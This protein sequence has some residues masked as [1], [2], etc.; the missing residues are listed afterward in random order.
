MAYCTI[1]DM[2]DILP[3]N[4]TIGDSTA[5]SITSAK[6]NS[7]STATASKFIY[8]ATQFIDS[9]LS[10]I[11]VIPLIKIRKISINIIANI[12]P[13]SYDVM[14]EDVSAFF[15][16]CTVHLSDDNGSENAMVG[17]IAENWIEGGASVKN[18]NHLTLA[19]PTVQAYDAGSNAKVHLLVYPDPIPVLTARLACSF[20]FDKLFVAEQ[21][22]DISNYGK[23]LR[24]MST[25]DMNGILSGQVRL[26]GQEFVSRRFVRNQLFDAVRLNIEN[27]TYEQGKE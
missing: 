13:G 12:M 8:F 19:T 11:Y 22:P 7:I 25:L 16:G 14:V 20:M 10:T 3:K 5:P 23:S 6:A 4:I 17:S 15:A 24:N 2:R 1:P 9:R 26:M 27:L 21:E 18:F